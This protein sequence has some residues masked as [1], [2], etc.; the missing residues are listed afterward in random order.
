M[1]QVLCGTDALVAVPAQ[2]N[3]VREP[4]K[5]EECGGVQVLPRRCLDC[6][7]LAAGPW[8]ALDF[9]SDD[10]AI[11]SRNGHKP[12][13]CCADASHPSLFETCVLYILTNQPPDGRV[14]DRGTTCRS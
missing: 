10:C 7:A 13:S 5:L 9:N 6:Y 4:W 8:Q 1:I 14:G 3:A 11:F 2:M 12:A